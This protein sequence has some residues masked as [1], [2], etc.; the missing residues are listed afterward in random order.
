[1]GTLKPSCK[2]RGFTLIEMLIVILIVGI[3]ATISMPYLI[4]T[5]RLSTLDGAA[6][7]L[8]S[9][10]SLTRSMA[11][12]ENTYCR[13]N[14]SESAGTLEVEKWDPDANAWAETGQVYELP[15]PIVFSTGGVTFTSGEAMFDPH[16]S[17][18]EGGSL[19]IDDGKGDA[20]T[21]TSLIAPGRLMRQ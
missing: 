14:I 15:Q 3:L 16:G 2:G 19:V 8:I 13:I 12:A 11:L 1:M 5:H 6:D 21:L 10:F 9:T 4:P 18:V 17:L 20:V 7:N